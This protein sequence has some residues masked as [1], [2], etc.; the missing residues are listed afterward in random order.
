MKLVRIDQDLLGQV[1]IEF[2]S[3]LQITGFGLV[4]FLN[5][6]SPDRQYK[7]M[8]SGLCPVWATHPCVSS[9]KTKDKIDRQME[10]NLYLEGSLSTAS[11][12]AHKW[13]EREFITNCTLLQFSIR[14]LLFVFFSFKYKIL[15]IFVPFCIASINKSC[16]AWSLEI[17]ELPLRYSFT[18]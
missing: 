10:N 16:L 15:F 13:E 9:A 7:Q 8:L 18:F 17:R 3:K 1:S 2:H 4:F 12:A 5:K 6:V 11:A 14:Y